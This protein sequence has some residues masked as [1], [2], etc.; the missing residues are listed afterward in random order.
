MDWNWSVSWPVRMV[1]SRYAGRSRRG[2]AGRSAV[3]SLLSQ[4]WQ[5]IFSMDLC[6]DTTRRPPRPTRIRRTF[7]LRSPG[8]TCKRIYACLAKFVNIWRRLEKIRQK[9]IQLTVWP[10]F[11]ESWWIVGNLIS[12]CQRFGELFANFCEKF[13]IGAAQKWL[14]IVDL[15]QCCNMSI[16]YLL[17]KT[18]LYAAENGPS[19]VPTR[20]R[21]C[22]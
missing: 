17:A 5:S 3:A 2:C 6:L 9:I 13:E 15:K 12:I 11:N 18:G 19:K 16:Y 22:T 21:K 7:T 4:L 20:R 1:L 8:I 14:N 10:K